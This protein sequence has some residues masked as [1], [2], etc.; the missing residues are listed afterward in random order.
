MGYLP[1]RP[2][3]SLSVLLAVFFVLTTGLALWQ[4]SK[5]CYTP[6]QTT[7]EKQHEVDKI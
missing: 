2:I 7:G 5:L 1:Y 6:D 3:I 4:F